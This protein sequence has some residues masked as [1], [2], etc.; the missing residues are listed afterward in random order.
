MKHNNKTEDYVFW[1]NYYITRPF[2]T[3]QTLLERLQER[4][5]DLPSAEH[6]LT[7]KAVSARVEHIRA[8]ANYITDLKSKESDSHGT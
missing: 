8:L 5:T 4:V 2:L 1:Y 6:N 3:M 7:D